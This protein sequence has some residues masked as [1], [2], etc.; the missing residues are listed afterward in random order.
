MLTTPL[1]TSKELI[2]RISSED[3][4][5]SLDQSAKEKDAL[6]TNLN[7]TQVEIKS[8][9]EQLNQAGKTLEECKMQNA[10]YIQDKLILERT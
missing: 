5:L 10:T 2:K 8:L 3:L 9:E 4:R 1:N 7:K 6:V